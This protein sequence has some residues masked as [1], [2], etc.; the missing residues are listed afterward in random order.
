[1][2]KSGFYLLL[3]LPLLSYAITAPVITTRFNANK[4]TL[5][6][7]PVNEA[8][9]Y[10]LYFAPNLTLCAPLENCI[11]DLKTETSFSYDLS[12]NEFYAIAVA[13]IAADATE[14]LSNIE[15][16]SLNQNQLGG[17]STIIRNNF[18][19]ANPIPNLSTETLARHEIGKTF[20]NRIFDASTGLGPLY[21]QS[22][23]QSCHINGGRGRPSNPDN[24]SGNTVIRITIPSTDESAPFFAEQL[25]DKTTDPA[26][27][28]H[29]QISVNYVES[30]FRFDDGAEGRTEY[31]VQIPNYTITPYRFLS[32]STRL[33]A[34]MP[35]AIFGMGL[36]AAVDEAEILKNEDPDDTKTKD[37][38]S[39]RA[40]YINN[41]AGQNQVARF[42]L[43]ANALT[44]SDQISAD[45]HQSM[46]ITLSETNPTELNNLNLYIQT[47]AVPSRDT[48]L[49]P[50]M[51]K[52]GEIHFTLAGCAACHI[53]TLKTGIVNNFP[54]LS[55]QIIHPYSDLLLH[56]MGTPLGDNRP[57]FLATGNEWRT[58][59]LWGIGLAERIA[60]GVAFYLH[61]GRARNITEA[62]MWHGGEALNAKNYFK[63]TT[64]SDINGNPILNGLNDQSRAELIEFIK[65]L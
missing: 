35:P 44:L 10:K 13:S 18:N 34:R 2:K 23:C 16:I 50:E 22:S 59:P 30:T 61:D 37:N 3:L 56:D 27:P 6:F 4:V 15:I 55:N 11:I 36:L 17:E 53:P 25:A 21:N 9:A 42:G 38:I 63:G 58:P 65:S 46:G 39:G 60:G 20:F 33:S 54:A 8:I 12:L 57:D 29:A 64:S 1:M 31:S 62:I 26:I 28:A 49:N 7:A 32:T 41:S 14:G 40:N 51:I 5:D 45:L 24:D 47:L 43:K 52:K 19:A 48:S